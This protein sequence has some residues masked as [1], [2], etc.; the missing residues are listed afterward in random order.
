ML[1]KLAAALLA[2]GLVLPYSCDVRPVE[3]LWSPDSVETWVALGI[4]VL[5]TLAYVLHNLV[6]PLARFHE[7]HGALLHGLFRM[8]YFVLV[9]FYLNEAVSGEAD[10][11]VFPVIAIVATG[12]LLYWQQRRGTKAQRLPL[13]L[14]GILGLAAIWQA[15]ATLDSG[16]LQIGG[17]L[18]SA[19]YALAVAVEIRALSGAPPVGG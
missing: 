15:L 7:R 17:W 2:A 3:V 1:R 11:W 16:H 19:G 10:A 12:A 5:V 9:G 8:V 14:L 4:P 13:L 18:Y 6:P